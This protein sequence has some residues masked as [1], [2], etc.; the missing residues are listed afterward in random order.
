MKRM[1]E[2]ADVE[3]LR[4]RLKDEYGG[5][6]A[7]FQDTKADLF[8]PQTETHFFRSAIRSLL[9]LSIMETPMK[10]G[11][12]G[13]HVGRLLQHKKVKAAFPAHNNDERRL[14]LKTWAREWW[15]VQPM[16]DIR[17]YFG[18]KIALYFAW[19]GYYTGWL[20][21]AAFV[22]VIVSIAGWSTGSFDNPG[23][24]VYCFFL[25]IWSTLF[26]EFWKR[27]QATLAFQWGTIGFE[28]EENPRPLFYGEERPG[29]YVDN[30]WVSL[31]D[32]KREGKKVPVELYYPKP[33]RWF[34]QAFGSNVVLTMIVIVVS[35]TVGLL[36][37][38][39]RLQQSA[40][41]GF[42]GGIVG[43]TLNSISILVLN[44]VYRNIA[45]KLTD[46][47]NH[48]TDTEYEDNLITKTFLFQFVNSYISLFYI[49]FVKQDNGLPDDKCTGSCMQE[50]SSQLISLLI[51][52][53]VVGQ[54]SEVAMPYIMTTIK[55]A[56]ETKQMSRTAKKAGETGPVKKPSNIER[57]AK[58]SVYESTFDDYNEMV[59]QFGY[60]TLFAAAFPLASLVAFVNNVIEI[61]TDAIKL[62][63]DTKRPVYKRAEDIG[64]WFGI[65]EVMGTI[66]VMTNCLVLIR[67]SDQLASWTGIADGSNADQAPLVWIALG[68]EHVILLL[69]YVI[70]WLIPDQ[71]GWVRKALAKQKYEAMVVLEENSI[72]HEADDAEG[73]EV[74]AEPEGHID[75]KFSE[76]SEAEELTV[77]PQI[78]MKSLTNLFNGDD[79]AGAHA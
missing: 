28:E 24:P 59:I 6:Y 16:E 15:K 44:Q 40:A 12:A 3:E 9:V 43:G 78:E 32:K 21:F 33:K 68:A 39:L 45:G 2:Q 13:L 51:T 61:R 55:I 36:L 1:K 23:V 64:T 29:L 22:G 53:T 4:L 60:V 10:R 54:I 65:L 17:N 69:K 77:A 75:D 30:E 79:A 20:F 74:K 76:A 27:E 5:G 58:M 14:L 48:R 47:E 70:A 71:P 57:Q 50:L 46:W 19:L 49:A 41:G 31:E 34:K 26:L 25:S 63:T 66:S 72:L 56:A 73:Q 67:T 18:E 37:A 35:A 52:K 7:P 62:L 8:E 11:G 42:W 38:R